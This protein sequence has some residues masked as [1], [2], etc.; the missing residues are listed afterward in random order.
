MAN[1]SLKK[2]VLEN[3]DNLYFLILVLEKLGYIKYKSVLT[4]LA[5][6]DNRELKQKIKKAKERY[7]FNQ[8]FREEYYDF[9]N[10]I[11]EKLK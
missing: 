3:S 9:E 4:A 10:K 6:K 2:I 11:Y 5:I 8:R 7:F 1:S